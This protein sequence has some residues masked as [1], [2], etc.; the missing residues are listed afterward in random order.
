[1]PTPRLE[2]GK[3]LRWAGS[4]GSP[5]RAEDHGLPGAPVPAER[6]DAVGTCPVSP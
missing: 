4:S 5:N 1:M 2:M 6:D 3:R